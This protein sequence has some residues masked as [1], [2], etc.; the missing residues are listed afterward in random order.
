[1]R[2]SQFTSNLQSLKQNCFFAGSFGA[3]TVDDEVS[4]VS[5]SA[6]PMTFNELYNQQKHKQC[7]NSV[8]NS[9]MLKYHN[10]ILKIV[11]CVKLLQ[12]K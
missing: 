6:N 3:S 1:M 11:L 8:E 9:M 2:I 7:Y 12:F 4:T 5:D 10:D